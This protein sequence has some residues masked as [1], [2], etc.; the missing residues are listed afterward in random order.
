MDEQVNQQVK[1]CQLCQSCDK[2]ATPAAAPLQPVPFPSQPWEKLAMDI[3]GPMEVAP[4][5]C[6]YAITLT[7]Y[8][9]KWPEVAFTSTVTSDNVITFLTS[10]FSRF[11]NPSSIVTDNGSQF[12][13]AEFAAFVKSRDIQHIRTSVYHPAANGAI[14][15]FHRVLKSCIQ[16]A[17]LER[18]P[19]KRLSMNSFRC[20]AL[21]PTPLLGF[22]LV[23]YWSGE[24]CALA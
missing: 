7:D 16:S 1:G 17:I 12:T 9:S 2:T 10:V 19:W 3:V 15:R 20:I 18:K 22:L 13:S 5:D 11:G 24:R 21:L 8:H 4:W 23:N 6:K 14:E